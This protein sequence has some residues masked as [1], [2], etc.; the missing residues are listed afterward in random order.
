MLKVVGA[1]FLN[2]IRL[3]LSQTWQVK[4]LLIDIVWLVSHC[5]TPSR[6]EN[7]VKNM[8]EVSNLQIDVMGNCGFK[9]PEI[10][11]RQARKRGSVN[12]YE[13]LAQQYKFYLREGP[14]I[15][16]CDGRS[17]SSFFILQLP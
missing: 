6:R 3:D 5:Q 12:T 2:L 10:P 16:F 8:K 7:Y 1:L 11:S 15:Y 17:L 14:I 13:I 9:N 4:L